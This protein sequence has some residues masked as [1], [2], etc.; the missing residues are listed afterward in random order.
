MLLGA[1]LIVL[2]FIC[3]TYVEVTHKTLEFHKDVISSYIRDSRILQFGFYSLQC[4]LALFG[5][6]QESVIIQILFYLGQIG[7]MMVVL[8]RLPRFYTKGSSSKL[9][10]RIHVLGQGLAFILSSTGIIMSSYE[11]GNMFLF[12]FQMSLPFYSILGFLYKF[13]S[14]DKERVVSTPLVTWFVLNQLF[15]YG[16]L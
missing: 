13:D 16:I 10:N 1:C 6:N 8:T 12:G 9:N 11:Q 15:T 7:Q 4:G 2:W 3:L 14:G 5:F